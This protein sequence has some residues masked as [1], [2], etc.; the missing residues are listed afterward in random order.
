MPGSGQEGVD[1][2]VETRTANENNHI[3]VFSLMYFQKNRTLTEDVTCC[4]ILRGW[5]TEMLARYAG[6]QRKGD[7]YLEGDLGACSSV[8]SH[9]E[10]QKRK[11]IGTVD[12]ASSIETESSGLT[13]ERVG[14]LKYWEVGHGPETQELSAGVT[15]IALCNVDR[16][17]SENGSVPLGLFRKRSL[18]LDLLE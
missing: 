7:L 18:E 2:A 3:A 11:W 4:D 13:R 9:V 14:W 12:G 16:Q 1:V 17:S 8:S 6:R 5:C 10:S 15:C